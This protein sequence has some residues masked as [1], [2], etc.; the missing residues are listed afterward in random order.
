MSGASCHSAPFLNDL[1]LVLALSVKSRETALVGIGQTK[2]REQVSM[3]SWSLQADLEGEGRTA[4][5]CGSSLSACHTNR[6]GSPQPL[7]TVRAAE[8]SAPAGT[9]AA[10]GP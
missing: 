3:L 2:G 6:A 5:R 9:V 10:F 7:G 8:R 4:P 1:G